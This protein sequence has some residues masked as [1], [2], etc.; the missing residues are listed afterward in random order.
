MQSLWTGLAAMQASDA[1]L[2]RVSNNIANQS[3]PGFAASRGSFADTYTSLV[4]ANA[5][6][7]GVAGRYTPQ[8]WR[9]GTGVLATS[10]NLDFSQMP[11]QQTGNPLDFAIRGSGFFAV[12]AGQGT[13]A[14]T[15]AGDFALSKQVDGTFVLA[16][17]SGQPVL[18]TLGRK[19]VIPAQGNQHLSVAPDGQITIGG[20]P[21]GQRLAI[22]GV[23][24]AS[25]KLQGIGN[26]LYLAKPGVTPKVLNQFNAPVG[27]SIA[28]GTLAMSNV[29]MAKTMASMLEAQRM[30]DL[31]AVGLRYTNQMM[32]TADS[33]RN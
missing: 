3:T 24:M 27:I 12:D 30:F 13:T 33:I 7:G 21:T 26:N 29:N 2:N 25:E 20:R 28:Q 23:S 5:T 16:T 6:A 17:Q 32:Q 14:L 22:M 8:G 18:D 15:K 4:L 31:N 9:G 10:S 19:I 11:L 1:W